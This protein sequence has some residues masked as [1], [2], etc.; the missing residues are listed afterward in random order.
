MIINKALLNIIDTEN[1]ML[2]NSNNELELEI[3]LSTFLD[4]MIERI[5][6]DSNKNL[7]EIS[8][9]S[10]IYQL[11]DKYKKKEITFVELSKEITE[12]YYG[13]IKETED[14]KKTDIIVLDFSH[15][16]NRYIASLYLE[17]K[18]KFIHNVN[19]TENGVSNSLIV[20][21]SILPASANIYM[22]INLDTNSLLFKDKK[23]KINNESKLIIPD[24]L[25]RAG[26]EM[27]TK[28]GLNIIKKAAIAIS[29]KVSESNNIV[30]ATK[31]YIYENS[32]ENLVLD[33]KKL[34]Q[35]V[36]KDNDLLK[37]EFENTITKYNV[38]EE[39]PLPREVAA[40]EGINHKITTDTGIEIT[41][42][43]E[44]FDNDNYINFINNPDG[45]ISIE[46]KNIGKITNR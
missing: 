36:F 2:I 34:A 33:T 41:F 15:L 30:A 1:D 19:M 12:S 43:S 6:E 14:L 44:Y 8:I 23:R 31:A 22:L 45:T 37:E 38:P 46:I 11:L 20:N 29:E 40:K 26:Y 28:K 4:K 18:E 39:L 32:K 17:N 24:L 10:N 42:P 3:G 5:F 35:T 7:G 16:G 13:F 25:C 27:S 9:N 21:N